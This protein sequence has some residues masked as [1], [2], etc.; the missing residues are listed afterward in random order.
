MITIAFVFILMGCQTTQTPDVVKNGLK[1]L[2]IPRGSIV[3][4]SDVPAGTRFTPG[5]QTGAGKPTSFPTEGYFVF[6]DKKPKYD[7][8]HDCQMVFISQKSGEPDILYLEGD[9]MFFTL[10]K[11]DGSTVTE[12]KQY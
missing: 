2:S 10:T 5:T 1:Q 8:P 9:P 12:C 3:H 11:P 4:Y 6:I 7:W